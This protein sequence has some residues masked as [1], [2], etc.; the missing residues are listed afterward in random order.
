MLEILESVGRFIFE[1]GTK[2]AIGAGFGLAGILIGRWRA[3]RRWNKR[4]FSDRVNISLNRI[5]NGVLKI[6]TIM[7]RPL[8]RIFLS[9]AAGELVRSTARKTTAD[10]PILP[11]PDR[12]QWFVMNEVLNSLVEHLSA[13]DI[14]ADLDIPTSSAWYVM[15]LTCERAGDI[16][17]HKIRVMLIRRD[18]L[19][20]FPKEC[21]G[22]EQASHETRFHTLTTL[23]KA[24]AS[25][26]Q[27]FHTVELRQ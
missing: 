9:S 20:D 19:I 2:F 10:D 4:N 24:Y 18:L 21:P 11:I 26:P 7:E 13:A 15:V 12:D 3:Q 1:H 6:R 17:T 16:R 23:A 8:E 22:L 5:D 14:K 25:A 27:K